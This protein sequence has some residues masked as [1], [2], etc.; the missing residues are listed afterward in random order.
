MIA[1]PAGR[2]Q[3]LESFGWA[4]RKASPARTMCP[5]SGRPVESPESSA[6][7]SIM[8]QAPRA[9]DIAGSRI[10]NRLPDRAHAPSAL[11]RLRA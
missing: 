6:G 11:A 10:A 2:E 4:G 5:E 9:S 8:R 7:D 3:A 1:H